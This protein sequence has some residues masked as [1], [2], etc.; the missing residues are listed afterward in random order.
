MTRTMVITAGRRDGVCS[1]AETRH[2]NT[3][4]SRAFQPSRRGRLVA[5]VNFGGGFAYARTDG[6]AGSRLFERD[7]AHID[8]APALK[9]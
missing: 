5:R 2:A 1:G 9:D 8:F 7:A 6:S 3:A 4:V